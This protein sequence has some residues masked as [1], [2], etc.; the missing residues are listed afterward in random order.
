MQSNFIKDDVIKKIKDQIDIVEYVS[1]YQPLQKQGKNFKGRCIFCSSKSFIVFPETQS[2]HCFA[3][4]KSGDVITYAMNTNNLDYVSAIKKICSDENIA[5][6]LT[7]TKKDILRDA[8]LYYHNQLKT[9]PKAKTAIDILHTW[10][11]QGK[12]IV[13]LGIGFHDDSYH[14]FVDYMV[15]V[16]GYTVAQLE[17]ARLVFKSA[18][19]SY[20]DKMRNSIIIPTINSNGEIL[21]FDFFIIDKQQLFHYP[22]TEKYSRS[23]NLY[24]LNLAEKSNSA[25][26]VLVTTY[27]DYFKLIGQGITNVVS[28]YMARITESQLELLKKKFKVILPLTNKYFNFSECQSFCQKNNMYCEAIKIDGFD[29][30]LEYIQNNESAIKDTIAKYESIWSNV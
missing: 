26:V 23:K 28:I 20:C 29:S 10:G 9:N 1:K 16:K 27:E 2:L 11:I 7:S 30:V 21:C 4:G 22:N 18:R 12:T 14:D 5:V 3:C 24:S 19:G 13:K 8:G 25:S 17:E 15:K 6:D